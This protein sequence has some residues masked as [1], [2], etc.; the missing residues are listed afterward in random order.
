MSKI[1]GSNL[2][3]E[4]PLNKSPKRNGKTLFPKYPIIVA[5]KRGLQDI[6]IDGRNNICH[7]HYS[8]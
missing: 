7:L 6:L 2:D 3:N 5:L 8:R 1:V 4:Y